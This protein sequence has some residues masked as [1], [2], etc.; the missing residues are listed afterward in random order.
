MFWLQAIYHR[1]W[2]QQNK[3]F[4]FFL[5]IPTGL[6]FRMVW[7]Q[8]TFFLNLW[9][10]NPRIYILTHNSTNEV[11]SFTKDQWGLYAFDNKLFFF[12]AWKVYLISLRP[13][14]KFTKRHTN[15]STEFFSSVSSICLSNHTSLHL[16]TV[17]RSPFVPHLTYQCHLNSF[18]FLVLSLQLKI[19]CSQIPEKNT[20]E[21]SFF[22]P[23]SF[24]PSLSPFFLPL[25]FSFTSSLSFFPSFPFPPCFYLLFSC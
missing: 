16:I 11:N 5:K 8:K 6:C 17:L 2:R 18:L 25:S 1:I 21:I 10:T 22:F 23:P 15:T 4:T 12:R 9:P 13:N 7:R 14:L 3:L 20:G 24:P 19:P